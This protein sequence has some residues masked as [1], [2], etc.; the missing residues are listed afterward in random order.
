MDDYHV[1]LTSNYEKKIISKAVNHVALIAME[2]TSFRVPSIVLHTVEIINS[3][4]VKYLLCRFTF[5]SL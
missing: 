2:S 3:R 5:G 4:L 1:F